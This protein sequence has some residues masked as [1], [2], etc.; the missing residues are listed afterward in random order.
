MTVHVKGSGNG[1]LVKFE[2]EQIVGACLNGAA[3]TRT[4]TM[5]LGVSRVTVS[6][7]M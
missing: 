6:K 1:R 3:V 5:L 4:A 7:V 2:R